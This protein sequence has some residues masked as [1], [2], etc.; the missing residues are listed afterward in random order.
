MALV[1]VSASYVYRG[2]GMMVAVVPRSALERTN[3][4]R[5]EISFWG[6]CVMPPKRLVY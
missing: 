5:D 3:D 2:A 4:A 1:V 6:H